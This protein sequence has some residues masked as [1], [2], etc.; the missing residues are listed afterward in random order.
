MVSNSDDLP[1]QFLRRYYDQHSD[2]GTVNDITSA[3][4]FLSVW[5]SNFLSSRGSASKVAMK[6][7]WSRHA[8]I[9]ANAASV[10]AFC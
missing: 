9:I 7:Q 10:T 2:F 8:T 4:C 1:L 6:N 5:V 3:S